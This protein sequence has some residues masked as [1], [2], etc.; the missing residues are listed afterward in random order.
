D[1][2]VE[3]LVGKAQVIHRAAQELWGK[4]D[5]VVLESATPA[6][7]W[8]IARNRVFV[9]RVD[10]AGTTSRRRPPLPDSLAGMR[11]RA[12]SDRIREFSARSVIDFGCGHGWLLAQ[13]AA[14]GRYTRLTG[15]DFDAA[16]LAAARTRLARAIGTDW[17][18]MVELREALITC[19]DTAFLGHEA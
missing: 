14:D 6:L 3:G 8:E 2:G 10:R 17:R 11:T 13:L 9:P 19:R 4:V 7:R 16:V 15:V 1:L 12:V 5:I 18:R